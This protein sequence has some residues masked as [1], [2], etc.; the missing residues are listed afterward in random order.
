MYHL[1][2]YTFSQLVQS[3][4]PVEHPHGEPWSHTVKNSTRVQTDDDDSQDAQ[5][6]GKV[7]EIEMF[8]SN[9]RQRGEEYE[10][11]DRGGSDTGEYK[12]GS[13]HTQS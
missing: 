10:T 4:T 11:H 2:L 5:Q 1:A 6:I 13:P 12:R 3:H 9:H 7:K 8:R